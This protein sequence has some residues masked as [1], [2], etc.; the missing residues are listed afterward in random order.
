MFGINSMEQVGQIAEGWT[1]HA[2]G[3]TPDFA[4][5]RMKICKQCPLYNK[6]KDTCDKKRC[7]DKENQ[8]VVS[9]PGKNIVC[10][11]G[12]YMRAASKVL[13]KKCVLGK[14]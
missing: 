11:C 7:W 8:S 14:W 1:K 12:C 3:I 6:E 13:H 4:E 5:E 2:L 9:Y 10:G